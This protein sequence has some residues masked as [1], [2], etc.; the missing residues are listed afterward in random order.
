MKLYEMVDLIYDRISLSAPFLARG[1]KGRGFGLRRRRGGR[2]RTPV[3]KSA[4]KAGFVLVILASTLPSACNPDT[5]SAS[6]DPSAAGVTTTIDTI[7]GVVRVTNTGDPP[8]WQLTQV[9]SIGPK[10]L[11]D[12]GSPDEFGRVYDFALGPDQSVYVADGLNNEIRVFGLDG[13]HRFT[14]G[15]SGEGPG[16]FARA[17]SVVWLGDRLLALDTEQGRISEFTA[18][19]EYIGQRRIRGGISGGEGEVRFWRVDTDEA[20]YFTRA[21]APA[22]GRWSE[23][24]G[25][26]SRGETGDTLLQLA[27]PRATITC[28]PSSDRSSFFGI[29]FG[30]K[31]VQR[32]GP[33]GVMYSALTDAY[34]IALTSTTDDTVRVIERSLPAEPISDEEWDDG[35]ARYRA[36]RDTFPLMRCDPARPPRPGAKPFIQQIDIAYD[37]T[38]WVEVLRETGNLW[39]VF[40]TEGGLLASL[41][42]PAKGS[43][44]PAIGAHHVLTVRKDSFGLDHVDVWRIER[45][46]P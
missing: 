25:V 32:P 41:P 37:G 38:L 30:A 16:E 18:E 3:T 40:D 2:C 24:V 42:A 17:Y 45:G 13:S 36:L 9:A 22:P 11:T 8:Q 21:L 19:G 14:F 28:E 43:L 5:D 29:P 23:F 1:P 35:N 10:S 6:G 44:P 31:L 39:E 27:G 33:G 7:D 12:D 46:P 34:R 26:D 4:R 20:Y 15:R